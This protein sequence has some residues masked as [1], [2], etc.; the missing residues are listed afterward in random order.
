MAEEWVKNSRSETRVALDA[1]DAAEAQLG[2]VPNRT[3][4]WGNNRRPSAGTR[5]LPSS[6]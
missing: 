1:R 4:N 3:E 6:L 5:M 2:E